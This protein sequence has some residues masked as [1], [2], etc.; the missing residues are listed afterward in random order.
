M[1]WCECTRH[2]SG[3]GGCKYTC[4]KARLNMLRHPKLRTKDIQRVVL[5]NRNAKSYILHA[6]AAFRV[7]KPLQ[8]FNRFQRTSFK[9]CISD[10]QHLEDDKLK[11]ALNQLFTRALLTVA[12]VLESA[13]FPPFVR[14]IL[15]SSRPLMIA[16]IMGKKGKVCL[17]YYPLHWSISRIHLLNCAALPSLPL[18]S[19]T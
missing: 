12:T 8:N 2:G 15:S 17:A 16:V 6:S 10:I 3:A 18:L 19:L 7:G 5:R 9:S 11:E 13:L 14:L 1:C 4:A